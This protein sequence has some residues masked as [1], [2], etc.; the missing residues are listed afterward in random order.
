[1]NLVHWD[2]HRQK[3][4]SRLQR[5]LLRDYLSHDIYPY[6]HY[7]RQ[8]LDSAGIE[9]DTFRE[10]ADFGQLAPTTLGIVQSQPWSFVLRPD[11]D[12]IAQFGDRRLL[13]QAVW[14]RVR[15]RGGAFNRDVIDPSYKPVQWVIAGG[16]PIGSSQ[17]DV[18]RLATAGERA[19]AVAGL[20]RD[21]V[22]LNLTS[23]DPTLAYLQLSCGALHS[24]ISS[25]TLST[26]MNLDLISAAAPSVVAGP[27][28][29][30]YEVL[31]R[32][33][34]AGLRLPEL[35][36]VV[37]LGTVL[38]ADARATLAN[39]AY[40]VSHNQVDVLAMWSPKGS[41]ALWAE[42][43]AEHGFHTYPD[44]EWV[45][46]ISGGAKASAL[47]WTS[48]AWHGTALMWLETGLFAHIDERDCPH[49]GRSVPRVF[50]SAT[51]VRTNALASQGA[52]PRG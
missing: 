1:M 28:R 50:P 46:S 29:T 32:L 8:L 51:P 14:A 22:L 10:V 24:G 48:L 17:Q 43:D 40:A 45:Y 37:V 47:M 38:G 41:R 42:C 27:A 11:E 52:L 5:S 13:R 44:L 3:D 34:N 31:T 25:L 16:L 35:R 18:D 26:E 36:R 2:R 33:V 9:P 7:Y 21:D 4:R 6:S 39:L 23:P 15:G 12:T 49:C 30:V 19:L 20:T